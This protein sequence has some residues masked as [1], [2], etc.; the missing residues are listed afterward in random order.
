MATVSELP[1][2]TWSIDRLQ[3]HFGGIAANRIHRYPRPGLARKKDLIRWNEQHDSCCELIDGVL[4]EKVV[5]T[6]ES[7]LASLLIVRLGIFLQNHPLGLLLGAD[8]SLEIIPHLVRLPDVSFLSWESI[9]ADEL[10]SVPVAALAPD[11]AVEVISQGNTKGE[12]QRKLT[13]YF[14]SGV[15]LVWLIYPKRKSIHV[16]ENAASKRVV[17]DI[18]DGGTV[19]PGFSLNLNEFFSAGRRRK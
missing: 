18:L 3:E 10:P 17:T 5:G 9:G 2:P 12:M 15:K 7:M 13:E 11:L 1:S 19:L 14:A 8:G 16:Y 6:R 4:V